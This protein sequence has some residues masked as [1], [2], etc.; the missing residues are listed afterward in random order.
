MM[1]QNEQKKEKSAEKKTKT[2]GTG[3]TRTWSWS[4][5]RLDIGNKQLEGKMHDIYNLC[6]HLI[7]HLGGRTVGYSSGS[8]PLNGTIIIILSPVC[9]YI[10]ITVTATYSAAPFHLVWDVKR[11]LK[12]TDNETMD[13][14]T[15]ILEC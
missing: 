9:G 8:R 11:A 14:V 7:Y 4:Q 3:G 2:G 13:Y 15:L 12:S 5:P 10:Y 1:L 6:R